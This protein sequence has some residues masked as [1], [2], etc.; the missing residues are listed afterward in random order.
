[1]MSAAGMRLAQAGVEWDAVKVGRFYALQ[2]LERIAN[3]GAVAVD[4][5]PP[6][7][8]LYFFVQVGSAVGWDVPESTGLSLNAHVVLPPD[9]KGA[10]PGPYWLIPPSH[11]LTQ[12]A[13]LRK[14]LEEVTMPAAAEHRPLDIETMRAS[15][16]RL[17][18]DDAER[19]SLED[20]ETLTITLRGHLEL[21]APEVESAALKLPTDSVPRY[22]ALACVGDAHGKLRAAAGPGVSGAVAYA[23]RLARTLSALCDHYE[24]L[25]SGTGS[26][27]AV[28]EPLDPRR[29]AFRRWSVHA[30]RCRVCRTD[31]TRCAR[32]R[33]LSGEYWQ[34]CRNA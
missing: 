9:D 11:G 16:H 24:S 27:S 4:P 13:G 22:C 29:E 31:E 30:V 34:A 6:E 21:L 14:A 10:P 17:L 2:A 5:A 32:G 26:R 28:D 12:A 1:M 18:T 8:A 33:R 15:A 19:P 25:G 7:P 20:I 23:L 3:P